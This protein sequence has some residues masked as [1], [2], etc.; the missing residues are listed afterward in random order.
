MLCGNT[1][2]NSQDS[3]LTVCIWQ[4]CSNWDIP[5][6][7]HMEM[8]GSEIP[9]VDVCTYIWWNPEA[10]GHWLEFCKPPKW[11]MQRCISSAMM[12]WW[13]SFSKILQA[14]RSDRCK[15]ETRFWTGLIGS[16]VF[17]S[18]GHLGSL[19]SD[20]DAKLKSGFEKL[21]CQDENTF[22]I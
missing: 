16:N 19:Q 17:F 18:N 11:L 14:S 21:D 20:C 15:V 2:C 9:L 4:D 3:L 13:S 22:T 8:Q 6:S 7:V 12:L 5:K 10:C 1:V